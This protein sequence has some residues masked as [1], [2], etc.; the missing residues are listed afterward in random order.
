MRLL[1]TLLRMVCHAGKLRFESMPHSVCQILIEGYRKFTKWGMSQSPTWTKWGIL[2]DC[3][4]V[5]A[6]VSALSRF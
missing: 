3:L 1:K 6:M 4:R 2:I 5:L